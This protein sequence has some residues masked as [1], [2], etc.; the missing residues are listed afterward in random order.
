M[1]KFPFFSFVLLLNRYR[2]NFP[3]VFNFPFPLDIFSIS[4]ERSSFLRNFSS[5]RMKIESLKTSRLFFNKNF[6]VEA[7]QLSRS[8]LYYYYYYYSFLRNKLPSKTFQRSQ[9]FKTKSIPRDTR[10]ATDK[11]NSL[12]AFIV[13]WRG[14]FPSRIMNNAA[15]VDK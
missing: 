3:L 1:I 10:W 6:L 12:P 2:F 8:N 5:S 7:A 13:A 9:K 11:G 15:A 4:F 14:G